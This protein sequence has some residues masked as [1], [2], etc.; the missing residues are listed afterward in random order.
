VLL[1]CGNGGARGMTDYLIAAVLF[2][3]IVTVLVLLKRRERR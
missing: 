3:F 2:I 1:R